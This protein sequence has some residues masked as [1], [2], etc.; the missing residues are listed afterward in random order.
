LRGVL[1]DPSWSFGRT[2]IQQAVV[3]P[4]ALA[5]SGLEA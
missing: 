1:P 3:P 2:T 5:I 4:Q